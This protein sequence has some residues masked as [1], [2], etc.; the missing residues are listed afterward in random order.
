MVQLV[1]H[2]PYGSGHDLGVLGMSPKSGSLLSGEPASP[3]PSAISPVVLSGSL[4]PS[5][6]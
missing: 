2:L 6:K 3:S 1:N 5:N 4:S